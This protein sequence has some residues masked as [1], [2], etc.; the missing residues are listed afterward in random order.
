[1]E[2]LSYSFKVR[3]PNGNHVVTIPSS[4]SFKDLYAHTSALFNLSIDSFQ[5]LMVSENNGNL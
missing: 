4:A 1:M 3:G 5:L 2:P